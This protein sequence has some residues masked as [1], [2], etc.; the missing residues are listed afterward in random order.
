MKKAITVFSKILNR[1]ELILALNEITSILKKNN[2]DRIEISFGFMWG[3]DGD[4]WIDYDI[5]TLEI[6]ER[7]EKEENLNKGKL[8]KDD[9]WISIKEF[10]IEILFCH[11]SDIH[12]CYNSENNITRTILDNWEE[13]NIIQ[14]KKQNRV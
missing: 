14:T 6:I 13:K 2:I 12:L 4:E 5:L 1:E 7:I 9:F 8:G 11:E 10:E 3:R